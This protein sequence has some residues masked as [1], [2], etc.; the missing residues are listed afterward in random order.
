MEELI[1]GKRYVV[2]VTGVDFPDGRHMELD[3]VVYHGRC[4]DGKVKADR[5]ENCLYVYTAP[6]PWVISNPPA[7]ILKCK[8]HKEGMH[9]SLVTSWNVGEVPKDGQCED[10]EERTD[11]TSDL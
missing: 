1:D 9:P 3:G 6:H 5:C 2:N 8:K 7:F 10:F 11:E 4:N